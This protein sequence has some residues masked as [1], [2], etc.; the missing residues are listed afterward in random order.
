MISSRRL[1]SS[2]P[3]PTTASFAVG[4]ARAALELALAYAKTRVQGGKPIIE[5]PAV[6]MRLGEMYADLEASRAIVLKASWCA[7]HQDPYDPKVGLVAK[8]V[9]SDVGLVRVGDS[10]VA[11]GGKVGGWKLEVG[12]RRGK[13][14]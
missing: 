6:A 8:L 5:H 4:M 2:L 1:M 9:A 7:D 3:R 12:G 10:N 14:A 11:V 13:K